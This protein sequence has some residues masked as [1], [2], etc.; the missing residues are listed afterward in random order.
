LISSQ[1]HDVPE[2]AAADEM[3][4][5]MVGTTQA[6]AVLTPAALMNTRRETFFPTLETPTASSH[7]RRRAHVITPPT[8]NS[9]VQAIAAI[10]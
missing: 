10:R 8:P 9:G 2:P 5:S 7:L 3:K 1:E 6:A 4:L